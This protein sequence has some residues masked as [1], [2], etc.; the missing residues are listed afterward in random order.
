[1]NTDERESTCDWSISNVSC[2]EDVE[3]CDCGRVGNEWNKV[4]SGDGRKVITLI[5]YG[6]K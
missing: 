2:V 1:M 4:R 6:D 3:S 5:S